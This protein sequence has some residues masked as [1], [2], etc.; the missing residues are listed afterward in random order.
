MRKRY[1]QKTIVIRDIF[2]GNLA[3][4]LLIFGICTVVILIAGRL[5]IEP[6][7]V[8]LTDAFERIT[9]TKE[10]KLFNQKN[11]Y[12]VFSEIVPLVKSSDEMMKKYEAL[13]GGVKKENS[14]TKQG[15]LIGKTFEETD[16]SV[17]EIGF[18]NQTTYP[19]NL[20][21]LKNMPLEF[22]EPGVLIV[23]T[24]TSE[25]Y[26]EE[27]GARSLDE[28]RNM[29]RIGTIIANTLKENGIKVIHDKTQNDYPAYNGSYNKALGV[30]QRNLAENPDIEVVLD[31]HRDYTVRTK[32]GQE[33]QLKPVGEVQG[34]KVSQVMLVVGTDNSGLSH[35][36]WRKNLAFAVKINEELDKISE[37]I[38]RN[39][40]VRK[41]RFNQHMTIGSLIIEVGSASNSLSESEKVAEYIGKAIAE[42]LKKY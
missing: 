28:N 37:N 25:A 3:F 13:Y 34:E 22:S 39:I 38:A 29:V 15:F 30:I 4:T 35:P 16:M 5:K 19:I 23:H 12:D 41:Q 27:E 36:Q 2:S 24:H 31:V 1:Y 6:D 40:N 17:S 14:S 26:A 7:R 32:D 42:V 8:K 10:I 21:E 20:A 18:N 9:A 33:I 11:I